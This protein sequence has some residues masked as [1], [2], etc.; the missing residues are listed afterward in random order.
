MQGLPSPDDMIAHF[1]RTTVADVNRVLR[2]YLDEHAVVAYA[3]P[4]NSGASPPAA[5]EWTRKTSDS[6]EHARTVAG[7]GAARARIFTCPQKPWRRRT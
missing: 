6:A 5:R 4:K 7:M 3:V 2:T 1:E